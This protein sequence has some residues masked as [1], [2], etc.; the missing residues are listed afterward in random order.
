MAFLNSFSIF[1]SSFLNLVS[2][3]LKRSVSLFFQ[4]KSLDLLIGSGSSGS[5]FYLYFSCSMSIGETIIHC[6]TGRLVL[7]GNVPA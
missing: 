7:C 3:R 6:G 2:I 5:S 1:I 4:E